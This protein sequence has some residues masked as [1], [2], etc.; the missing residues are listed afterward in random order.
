MM[1]TTLRRVMRNKA[2]QLFC[3]MALL[4][5]AT[6]Y[7]QKS[8]VLAAYNY[9][10][11]Y[12]Q[13]LDCKELG[14]AVQA[15]EMSLTDE[16]TIAWAKTWYYRGNIYYNVY[17][18]QDPACK[19]LSPTALDLAHESYEKALEYDEKDRYKKEVEPKMSVIANLY[20]LR[21]AEYF[22]VKEF[23]SALNDF[24][25]SIQISHKFGKTDSTALY[26]AALASEKIKNYSKAAMYYEGLIDIGYNEARIF[27]FL[28]EANLNLG[29]TAKALQ[30]IM[31]GRKLYPRNQDLIIDELNFYL[32]SG[33]T[34]RALNNLNEAISEMP[35]NAQLFFARGTLLD[36][37][38]EWEKARDAYLKALEI[39]PND[40]GSNYNLGAL[41]FNKGVE[42][43]DKAANYSESQVAEFKEAEQ[44]S[45]SFFDL[46]LPYLEKANELDP[47]DRATMTSL[48]NLYS[49]TG[50][51]AGYK[52]ISEILDN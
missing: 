43:V 28:S 30:A 18:S 51:D 32:Q 24:E 4:C 16:K 31:S 49:R 9:E 8:K 26:N 29:D 35:D 38:G 23:E 19:A 52:R 7:A 44:K 45:K 2:S 37:Q 22:N 36:K 42:Y 33:E 15:I 25:R 21:G 13:S 34:D 1:K 39:S 5:P 41:Y 50:N 17:I 40:F 11:S 27:H 14:K 10:L 48:K 46:S 12:T 47:H 3:C 20:L 6:M